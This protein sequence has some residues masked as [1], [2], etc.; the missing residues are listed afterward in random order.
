MVWKDATVASLEVTNVACRVELH[1][2][3]I[4]PSSR[5]K[6]RG[7]TET[8]DDPEVMTRLKPDNFYRSGEEYSMLV[9]PIL[10][11]FTFAVQAQACR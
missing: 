2:E 5:L 6:R 1:G 8:G 7:A 9:Y 11:F 4:R 10:I 3:G